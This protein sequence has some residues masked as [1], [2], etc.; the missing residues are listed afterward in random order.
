VNA[1]DPVSHDRH[2]HVRGKQHGSER[3]QQAEYESSAA[4]ELDRRNEKSAGAQPTPRDEGD[5]NELQPQA[6]K[7]ATTGPVKKTTSAAESNGELSARI[8]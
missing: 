4:G 5:R 6:R 7:A 1:S 2:Y 3:R 8:G